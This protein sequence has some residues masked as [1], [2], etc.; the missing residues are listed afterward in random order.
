[1]EIGDGMEKAVKVVKEEVSVERKQMEEK[2]SNIVLYGLME[3]EGDDAKERKEKDGETVKK[4]A[5]AIGVEIAGSIDAKYR[6]GKR[7]QGGE[8]SPT[9]FHHAFSTCELARCV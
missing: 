3:A 2:A 4:I 1:M 7:I 5:L 8:A 9:R 6:A